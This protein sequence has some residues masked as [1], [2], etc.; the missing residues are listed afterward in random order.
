MTTSGR[1]LGLLALLGST[2]ASAE[3]NDF[4]CAE[5]CA[6]DCASLISGDCGHSCTTAEVGQITSRYCNSYSYSYSFIH[7]SY[8]YHNCTGDCDN[9]EM[10]W[11]KECGTRCPPDVSASMDAHCFSHG[12]S[13]SYDVPECVRDCNRECASDL[14]CMDDC[15]DIGRGYICEYC[16]YN[17]DEVN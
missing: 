3:V 14:S 15:D 4:P 10:W 5:D 7:S 13:H 17:A 6:E 8:D 11:N 2:L 12:F 9:C 16:V 1:L